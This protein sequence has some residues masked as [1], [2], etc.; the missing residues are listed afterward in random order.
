MTMPGA[1]WMIGVRT[2]SAI[3]TLVPVAVPVYTFWMPIRPF[4][5][6]SDRTH[7]PSW[8]V[9]NAVSLNSSYAVAGLIILGLS[10]SPVDLRV[11]SISY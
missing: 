2:I 6:S 10:D 9:D 11:I 5:P 4:W 3:R 7:N 8:S 1:F